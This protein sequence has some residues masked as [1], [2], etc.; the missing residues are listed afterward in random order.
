MRAIENLG[1]QSKIILSFALVLAF[2]LGLGGFSVMRLSMLHADTTGIR[3]N[4][5][6]IE[7]LANVSIAAHQ[8]RAI[9]P[10]LL[11]ATTDDE[12]RALREAAT[13]ARA[14]EERSWNSYQPTVDP[15]EEAQLAATISTT[16]AAEVKAFDR[17]VARDAAGDPAGAAAV[18]GHDLAVAAAANYAA[19]EADR[20]YQDQQA[21][22]F[23]D[24]SNAGYTTSLVWIAAIVGVSAAVMVGLGWLMMRVLSRPVVA[25]TTVMRRLAEHDTAVAIPSGARRDEIGAMAKTLAVFKDSM[26]KTAEMAAAERADAAAKAEREARVNAAISAFESRIDA[27]AGNLSSAATD[28]LGAAEV[29]SETAADSNAKATDVAAS[30]AQT[31]NNV[32]AVAAAT[33]QMTASLGEITRRVAQAAQAAGQAVQT[34]NATDSSMKSLVAGVA[35]ISTIVELIN[36]IASQTNL[37]AL[38]ATIEAARAGD[39]GKGFAVVAAE[40]KSLATQT[41]RATDQ[42]RASIVEIQAMTEAATGNLN[43]VT[44]IIS[45]ISGVSQSIAA[46][47]EQQAATTRDIAQNVQEASRG[48]AGVVVRMDDLRGGSSRTG[49][50]AHGVL[51]AARRVSDVAVELREQVTGFLGSLKAS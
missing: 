30:S 18:A 3:D 7:D 25:L 41:A 28:M 36:T 15:G 35:G 12:K 34:V 17:L 37:L 13:Q 42:V 23:L 2:S 4:I 9:G 14:L 43:A 48:V 32:Q 27:V 24:S 16:W 33:E 39:A 49:E 51:G 45:D 20:T 46:A 44:G 29:L 8:I 5:V 10:A 50:N 1:I 40:V 11:A 22:G 26:V 47:V 38:N 6:A 21:N 19:V 31:S